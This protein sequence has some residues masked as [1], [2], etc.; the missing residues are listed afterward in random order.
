MVGSSHLLECFVEE[1]GKNKKNLVRTAPLLRSGVQAEVASR[2]INF[3][4]QIK[5]RN[6]H[7]N[8]RAVWLRSDP[9]RDDCDNCGRSLRLFLKQLLMRIDTFLCMDALGKLLGQ[10]L[11]RSTVKS[12]GSVH[13][14]TLQGERHRLPVRLRS[15]RR[16]GSPRLRT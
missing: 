6:M 3:E 16:V 12:E 7:Q 14:S 13:D 8:G 10:R 1:V 9:G 5:R 15:L 4:M 11:R 2:L